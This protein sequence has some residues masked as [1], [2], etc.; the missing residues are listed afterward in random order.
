MKLYPTVQQQVCKQ[1]L[2]VASPVTIQGEQPLVKR[3]CQQNCY[4]NGAGSIFVTYTINAVQDLYYIDESRRV[5]QE[6]YRMTTAQKNGTLT[7][8]I[9][10][11]GEAGVFRALQTLSRQLDAGEVLVGEI[12]DYP[13]FLHRGYIEGFYGK[14]WSQAERLDMLQL[15]ARHQMNTYYYAPKDDPFHREKW[16]VPYPEKELQELQELIVAAKDH[17]VDFYFCIAPGLSMQYASEKQYQLLLEKLRQ[18]Y[19]LGVRHFGLLLDDIPPELQYEEDIARFGK[20]T[21]NAHIYLC[22]RLFADLRAIDNTIE[23]T[24]CPVQYCGKGDEPFISRMGQGLEPEISIFWTGRNV[25]SQELTMMEAVTFI[26]STRHKPLY[27]DNFPVN[28]AEMYNEMHLGYLAGR[29][30]ELYR[31]SEGLI[32]NCMEYCESTKIPL[33]TV[34][35]Y[36]WNPLAYDAQ[37]SWAYAMR[38][39]VGEDAPLFHYYADLLLTSCLKVEDMSPL[40]NTC[41]RRAQQAIRRGDTGQALALL[42]EYTKNLCACCE[43]VQNQEVKLYRELATWT[44]KLQQACKVLTTACELLA[45]KDGALAQTLQAQLQTYLQMP[46]VLTEFSFQNAVEYLLLLCAEA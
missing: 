41:L 30:K 15:M 4:A 44:Q 11:A 27:W 28:D 45:K 38:T 17:F 5:T 16:D 42:Q 25:C 19:A 10:A 39:V 46:R 22:N 35:D 1:T 24:M 34:A 20:E 2:C 31:Y 21:V 14:P 6:K 43:L 36:L 33:L 37:A 8:A 12:E 26:Q 23:L 9:A 13:M 40:L 7:V 29:D 18:I 32:A 3:W